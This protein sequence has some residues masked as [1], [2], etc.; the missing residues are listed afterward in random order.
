[1]KKKKNITKKL[2]EFMKSIGIKIPVSIMAIEAIRNVDY[3]F[4]ENGV[5]T[6]IPVS[7]FCL[8][9]TIEIA[10]DNIPTDALKILS[11]L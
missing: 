10:S 4:S 3:N 2:N 1:M 7:G 11:S 8:K 9:L 5:I 6:P